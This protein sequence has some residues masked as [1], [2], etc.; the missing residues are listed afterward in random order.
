MNSTEDYEF[1]LGRS[2]HHGF[3]GEFTSQGNIGEKSFNC[4]VLGGKIRQSANIL[5][6]KPGPIIVRHEII[7]VASLQHGIDN[8]GRGIELCQFLDKSDKIHIERSCT[9][10]QKTSRL[11]LASELECF[12]RPADMV[13]NPAGQSAADPR[14]HLEQPQP[15]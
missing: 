4:I 1:L 13:P 7:I 11:R 15:C 8:L 5:F 2:G 12:T 14:Q 6:T 9:C 3:A 10:R